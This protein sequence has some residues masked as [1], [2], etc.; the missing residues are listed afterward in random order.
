MRPLHE[1]DY[2]ATRPSRVAVK[3]GVIRE[4]GET[5]IAVLMER[6]TGRATLRIAAHWHVEFCHGGERII[7]ANFF[8]AFAQT[9]GFTQ[10]YKVDLDYAHLPIVGSEAAHASA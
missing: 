4:D 9:A 6:A 8:N 10:S 2:V 3:S 1:G 5:G 7:G